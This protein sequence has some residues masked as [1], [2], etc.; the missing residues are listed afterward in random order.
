MACSGGSRLPTGQR[1]DVMPFA[2]SSASRSLSDAFTSRAI[3]PHNLSDNLIDSMLSI[4]LYSLLLR[5]H[6][7]R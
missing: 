4:M 2:S 1:P 5:R 6:G 3:A 7:A